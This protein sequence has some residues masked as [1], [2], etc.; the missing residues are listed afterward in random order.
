MGLELFR[1]LTAE[2]Q[3]VVT[4]REATR[5]LRRWAA[6]AALSD[7]DSLDDVLALTAP[8]AN[9]ADANA[10]LLALLR[11]A[12]SDD[13]A[14]RA[15]L[16]ALIPGL[17]RVGRRMGAARDLD[18][19]ADVIAAAWSRIRTYPCDRRPDRVAA[20]VVLDVFHALWIRRSQE[21]AEVPTPPDELWTIPDSP[22]SPLD[23]PGAREVL[24]AVTAHGLVPAPQAQLVAD[25]VLD[26]IPAS[27]AATRQG[28]TLKAMSRRRERARHRVVQAYRGL[29]PVPVISEALG[30]LTP[31][32]RT[33]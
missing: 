9:P 13:I 19:A 24:E 23:R 14:A 21:L 32:R 1:S 4:S 18:V 7:M 29:R 25:A 15:A 30:G 3:C 8:G 20:N 6:D 28:I 27:E 16:Q 2:W 10:V 5:A 12:S 26:R 33:P 22:P 17:V 31:A 11:R